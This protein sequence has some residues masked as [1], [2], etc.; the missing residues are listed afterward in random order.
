MCHK[1]I[2]YCSAFTNHFFIKIMSTGMSVYHG[3]IAVT[4]PYNY[5]SNSTVMTTETFGSL[6]TLPNNLYYMVI[7]FICVSSQQ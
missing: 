3:L 1:F 5:L 6:V 7:Q 4:L 2:A